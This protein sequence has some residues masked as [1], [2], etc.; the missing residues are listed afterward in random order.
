MAARSAPGC[1][2]AGRHAAG[3][4]LTRGARSA[5]RRFA[6]RGDAAASCSPVE[7]ICGAWE[8][9]GGFVF[10]ILDGSRRPGPPLPLLRRL[11]MHKKQ[12][13]LRVL[14][15][16]VAATALWCMSPAGAA[17]AAQCEVDTPVRFSGLNWESNLVLAGIERF[18]VEHGYGCDTSV[19]IVETLAILAALQTGDVEVTPE[20]WPGQIEVAWEKALKSGKALAA[21]H[22]FDAGEGWYT[23]RY[24]AERHPDLTTAADLKRYARTFADPEDPARGRIYG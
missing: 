7:T 20:V 1:R 5:A 17:A 12:P 16:L 11:P 10:M 4:A 15:A 18:I 13:L 19:E 3:S 23:P 8:K 6:R 9:N 2:A 21:G 14:S 22:V 24:T